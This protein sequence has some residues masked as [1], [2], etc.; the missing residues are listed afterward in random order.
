MLVAHGS[1]QNRIWARE[2]DREDGPFFCPICNEPVRLHKGNL[3]V[4]HF[5]HMP[6]ASC[7]YGA[8]ESETHRKAKEGIQL[9]FQAKGAISV[10]EAP[11]GDL[12]PDIMALIGGEIV[13][14]EVQASSISLE[15]INRRTIAY[16]HRGMA[17]AW[18]IC[19]E[20][21][22]EHEKARFQWRQRFLH[23]MYFG[24]VYYYAGQDNVVPVHLQA[25]YGFSDGGE[26]YDDRTYRHKTMKWPVLAPA[27]S[28]SD[29]SIFHSLYRKA[30]SYTTG[31]KQIDYPASKIWIDQL[32]KWWSE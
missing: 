13:G 28:L 10:L 14:I 6:N 16:T 19:G 18:L 20:L 5:A 27:I 11:L 22:I 1:N 3:R 23:G 7:T 29:T 9:A 2:I 26:Y 4:H 15:E 32:P 17:V 31:E 12:R 25:S 8:G 30:W 24:R 21:P